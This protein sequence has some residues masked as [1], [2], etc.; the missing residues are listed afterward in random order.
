M[1]KSCKEKLSEEVMV[2]ETKG[3]G[4]EWRPRP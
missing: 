4:V 3:V 2:I 1:N